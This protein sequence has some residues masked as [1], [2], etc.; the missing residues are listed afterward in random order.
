MN[1]HGLAILSQAPHDGISVY[2]SDD[3]DY[4]TIPS[5]PTPRIGP[6][7]GV[8]RTYWPQNRPLCLQNRACFPDGLE[9]NYL[10]TTEVG[11]SRCQLSL[12]QRPLSCQRV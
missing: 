2:S 1:I 9:A 12:R 6:E 8:K 4:L 7:L 3:F 5:A 10:P 11:G